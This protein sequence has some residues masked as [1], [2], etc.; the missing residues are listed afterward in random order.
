M[1]VNPSSEMKTKTELNARVS[2]FGQNNKWIK[3]NRSTYTCFN[4]QNIKWKMKNTTA[5][6]INRRIKWLLKTWLKRVTMKRLNCKFVLIVVFFFHLF[7]WLW[8]YGTLMNHYCNQN[9]NSSEKKNRQ[10]FFTN[11]S[12]LFWLNVH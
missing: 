2:D 7:I 8:Y 11:A 3:F 5:K 6:S 12:V 1:I 10:V 4:E 9:N